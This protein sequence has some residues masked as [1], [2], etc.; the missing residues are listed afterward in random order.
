LRIVLKN[1]HILPE[2]RSLPVA[3]GSKARQHRD[4][5]TPMRNLAKSLPLFQSAKRKELH[6]LYVRRFEDGRWVRAPGSFTHEELPDRESVRA[7]FGGGRYEIIGRD[8]SKIVA[9]TRFV[10]NGPARPLSDAAPAPPKGQDAGPRA[11]AT[12]TGEREALVFALLDDG[13]DVVD[14]TKRTGIDAR[15]VRAIFAEWLAP[16]GEHASIEM[17]RAALAAGRLAEL[18]HE[19]EGSWSSRA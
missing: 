13:M 7:R 5:S 15:T 18:E 11:F 1:G 2:T 12:V 14:V 17:R 4:A 3:N 6:S 8:G 10:E 9:R 19:W 16:L